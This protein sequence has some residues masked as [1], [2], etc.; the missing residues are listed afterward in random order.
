[1]IQFTAV[2]HCESHAASGKPEPCRGHFRRP[3]GLTNSSASPAPPKRPMRKV[4]IALQFGNPVELGGV[5]G[6]PS[7]AKAQH[8]TPLGFEL[9]TALL[10]E[11]RKSLSSCTRSGKCTLH[12]HYTTRLT[13]SLDTGTLFDTWARESPISA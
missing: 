11:S 1:M 9:R 13:A 4:Y 10:H 8:H 12:S 3:A 7:E 5:W 2:C 6:I